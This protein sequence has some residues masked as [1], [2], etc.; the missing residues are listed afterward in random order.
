LFSGLALCW[1]VA[2]AQ[3]VPS[4][5]ELNGFLVGQ[6]LET[7]KT[8]FGKPYQTKVPE[9]DNFGMEV[10]LLDTERGGYM[11]FVSS[12]SHPDQMHT[13]QITGPPGTKMR[14]F[15]GMR[16]GDSREKV[17]K[18]LGQPSATKPIK[19][20]PVEL[21]SYA[22]RNYSVELDHEGRL[23]SIRVGG[24]EGFPRKLKDDPSLDGLRQA[25]Q[26]KNVDV[27]LDVPAPDFEIYRGDTLVRYD[28]P[29]REDLSNQRSRAWRALYVG[30]GNLWAI[31]STTILPKEADLRLYPEKEE[32][33]MVFKFSESNALQEIVYRHAGN[34]RA[35]EILYRQK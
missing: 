10:Y 2:L 28:G 18:T 12:P 11:V 29:A 13:I 31:L 9:G 34:W 1:Q 17:I 5:L 32:M 15:L 6:Y 35:W 8:S 22:E 24:H 25:L 16:L 23:F 33:A 26:S 4:Q 27:L 20:P 30:P 19:N 3:G 7:A 21:L 14:P